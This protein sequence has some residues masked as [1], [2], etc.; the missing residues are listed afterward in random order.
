M[1]PNATLESIRNI[2][3]S[4]QEWETLENDPAS[5]LDDLAELVYDLDQWLTTGGL[6]PDDWS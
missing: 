4:W 1:D 2:C 3:T 5:T 6:R